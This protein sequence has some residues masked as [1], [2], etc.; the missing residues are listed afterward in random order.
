MPKD[1]KHSLTIGMLGA[2]LIGF[3]TYDYA[4]HFIHTAKMTLALDSRYNILE[5]DNRLIRIDLF[6][7]GID[8]D[9]FK[10]TVRDSAVQNIVQG[11]MK[12]SGSKKIIF[13][14]DRLDYTKG[15]NYR[16]DGF[17]YF[18]EQYP[19]WREK[20]IFILNVIPSRDEIPAYIERKKMIEEKVSTINGKYSTLSWQPLMYRY[21]HIS[22]NELVALY[23]IA[24]VALI[25][26]LR[27]GMN[28]VA[29][30]YVASCRDSGVLILSEL[31]GAA[32][33]LN[34]AIQINPTDTEQMSQAIATA[35]AMPL[36]E[37]K[38]RLQKMKERLQDYDVVAW[39]SDFLEQLDLIKKQQT[40][41]Q[42]NVVDEKAIAKMKADYKA[43]ASRC[44]LLDYDGTLSAFTKTPS[45]A[46]PN[47]DVLYFLQELT[48][49]PKNEV[50][51]IS[52]RDSKT[53]EKWLGHLPLNFVTEHGVYIK[54]KGGDWQTQ[55]SSS[56]A[57]KDQVRPL[58]QAYV[59]RC[60]GSLME[61]KSHSLAWHYRNTHPGLGFI[62][63]RELLNNLSQLT[64]NSPV[65]V[66]DGNKVLEVR[67][68]GLNKGVMALKV[69]EKFKSDFVLCIGD[70]TTDEDM[71]KVLHDRAYTI[72]IGVGATSANHSIGTQAEV[73]SF[74]QKV[75]DQPEK[76]KRGLFSNLF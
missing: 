30:E 74:L 42:V 65:Q 11:L 49:D 24:N 8:V 55:T 58:L 22:F 51:I 26:P 12:I 20:V 32:S 9:K 33:E 4:Q 56:S 27:D 54:Y 14:V 71:F 29:K 76:K 46:A 25:T 2:D 28:L 64:S 61:E 23:N 18:L 69:L 5:Y 36:Q 52:G 13:S 16:L 19:E 45:E 17:E 35:L 47:K 41:Q 15:I 68:I 10:D 3:H 1:W 66:I 60:A 31:T 73:L 59:S 48:K 44:I 37:Q 7:I 70:D 75:T 40:G 50:V 62:R 63:S 21:N 43:A 6:P 34:E 72:R 39:V 53:L 67:L 57:W 38:Q